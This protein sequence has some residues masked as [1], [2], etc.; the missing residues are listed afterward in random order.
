MSEDTSKSPTAIFVLKRYTPEEILS[1]EFV[2]MPALKH[3]S[4]SYQTTS[5]DQRF[6]FVQKI[7]RKELTIREAASAFG[8]RYSTAKTIMKV[9]KSE[10]RFEKKKKRLKKGYKKFA[11]GG[12][13]L[14]SNSSAAAYSPTTRKYS[15]PYVY[16]TAGCVSALP[17]GFWASKMSERT[18]D[19]L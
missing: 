16:G 17:E 6:N 8:I 10:G 2:G 9:Y 3:P 4:K 14:D 7:L 18:E 19:G 13:A 11:A 5:D 12:G 15:Y 1:P